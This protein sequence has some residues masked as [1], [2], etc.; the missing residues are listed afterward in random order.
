M[1]SDLI[2]PHTD[3]SVALELAV[4]FHL[5]HN[6]THVFAILYDVESHAQTTVT[7]EQLNHAVHRT[8]HILNPGAT[9]PQGTNLGILISTDTILYVTLVL[10]AMR[11][12]LV[13]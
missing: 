11:A 6:P 7:Y 12:G 10:G 3:G 2:L 8:A 4:D 5:K 1:G 13:V 9:L